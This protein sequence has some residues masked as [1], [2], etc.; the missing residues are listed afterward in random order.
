MVLIFAV[1]F[2]IS[3]GPTLLL[4]DP[5][6]RYMLSRD[7]GG[8]KLLWERDLRALKSRDPGATAE[9]EERARRE[10]DLRPVA[11]ILLLLV[12]F[13]IIGSILAYFPILPHIIRVLEELTG[14]PFLARV[15]AYLAV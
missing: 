6:G 11:P 9:E 5:F 4:S 14:S 1:Y 8:V 12:V 7:V 2:A 10:S 13:T 3:F 15:L